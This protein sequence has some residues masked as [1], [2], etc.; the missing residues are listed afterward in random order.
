VKL[1]TMSQTLLRLEGVMPAMRLNL[2]NVQPVHT[3]YEVRRLVDRR[4]KT[5]VLEIV[6]PVYNEEQNVEPGIRR[7]RAYLDASSRCAA[8]ITVTDNGST[9]RTPETPSLPSKTRAAAMRRG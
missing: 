5:I 9:D 8:Q 6:D 3:Q 1:T 2:T 4:A 7:L